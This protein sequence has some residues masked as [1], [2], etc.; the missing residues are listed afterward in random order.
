MDLAEVRHSLAVLA[1]PE[2]GIQ[3][4]AAPYWA[5]RTFAAADLEKATE[6]VKEQESATG[7]YYALN[8]VPPSLADRVKNGDVLKRRW[9]LVD[10]DRPKTDADADLSATEAE[11]AQARELAERVLAYLSEQGWPSPRVVDSG[12]GFHLLYRIDLPNDAHAR[13]LCK[14][15]LYHLAKRFDGPDGK[16]G[17]ECHDARR[18]AKLPGTVSKRGAASKERPHRLCQVVYAPVEAQA[19]TAEQLAALVSEPPAGAN[20]VGNGTANRFSTHTSKDGLDA[21]VRKAVEG[22]RARVSLSVAGVNRNNALNEAAFRLGTLVGAG[23]LLESAAVGALEEVALLKGLPA[24][25]TR[26][27]IQSG[28]QAGKLQP[29]KLP[30][31]NGKPFQSVLD[32]DSPVKPDRLTV[33]ASKVESKHVEWLVHNR[34]PKRFITVFAGR[35]GLGKS[36]VTCDLIAR[37]TRG[38]EVP[39]GNGELF[40]AGGALLISEDPYEYVLVPRLLELK[41]D[42]NKVSFMTWEAMASY[43]LQDVAMLDRAWEEAG[44]PQLVGIDPPTNFLGETDEHKNAEVRAVLKLI[45]AWLVD[46]DVAV[47]LITHVNKQ[48]GKGVD[49]INRVM[50]SVAWMTSARIGHAFTQDPDDRDRCLWVPLKSNLGALGKGLAYRIVKTPDLATVEWQGEVDTTAD[51]AMA[52]EKG[53]PRRVVASQWLIERF[54]EKREW[55]SE[56]LFDAARQ[57]GVSRNAIFEAKSSLCLPRAR[58]NVGSDGSVT[59][60]WWVPENWPPLEQP[61]QSSQETLSL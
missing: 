6:W 53:V 51:E 21:Y 15:A 41:A 8:P 28:M 13:S 5:F 56:A 60:T 14:A 54:R 27:T 3:L 17:V 9:L 40:E 23:A 39:G 22:E 26:K 45:S 25:E 12:N 34:I 42:L 31:R 1:D 29:R 24:D 32:P 20:H 43:T 18:I 48:T 16:I 44:R 61:V 55:E 59:W 50:G 57:E 4:Q 35:T 19:V 11:H 38:G 46:R 52:G 49:A 10:V 58:R 33:R 2:H 7:I 47:I 36:F 30:E 37:M